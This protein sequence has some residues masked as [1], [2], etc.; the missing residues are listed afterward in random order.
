MNRLAGIT[1]VSAAT[2]DQLERRRRY[3]EAWYR[4]M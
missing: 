2:L 3:A 4:R 1:K